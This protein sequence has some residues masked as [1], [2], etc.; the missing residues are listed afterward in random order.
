MMCTMCVCVL[1]VFVFHFSNQVHLFLQERVQQ[2]KQDQ[3]NRIVVCQHPEYLNNNV[4]N[5]Q[6]HMNLQ[7]KKK[8]NESIQPHG[9]VCVFVCLCVCVL[10]CLCVCVFV[11]LCVC[12]FVCLC[13]CVF[14][15]LCVCVFVSLCVCEFVCL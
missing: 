13:V 3:L 7:T 12:V 2:L 6:I 11:C 4:I 9:C 14:V 5:K 8:K 1:F 15:C 10:V